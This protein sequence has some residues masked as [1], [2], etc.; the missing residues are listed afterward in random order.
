MKAPGPAEPT[1]L[2]WSTKREMYIRELLAYLEQNW[3][4]EGLTPQQRQARMEKIEREMLNTETAIQLQ[5]TS[6]P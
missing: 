5:L 1:P 2:D 3:I 4:R 6:T